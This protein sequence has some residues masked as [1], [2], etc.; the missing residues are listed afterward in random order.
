M[1]VDRT[2]CDSLW[3]L[4]GW[5]LYPALGPNFDYTAVGVPADWHH[6]FTGFASHW[7]KNSNT[8]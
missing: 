3:I 7:N 2:C 1:A 5:A 6:N 8:T 4:A